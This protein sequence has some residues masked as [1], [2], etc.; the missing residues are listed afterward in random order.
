MKCEFSKCGSYRYTLWRAW[1]SAV[2][3]SD[4]F[5]ARF[6]AFIGLNPSTA[7]DLRNDPT[8]RRCIGFARDWGF[9]AFCML[10]LFA[11][12]TP[13]P[14]ALFREELPVGAFNNAW[15]RKIVPLASQVIAAW[16]IHGAHMGRAA[17]V[18]AM[19]PKLDCLGV[20]KDGHPR[21]PLYMP[22]NTRPVPFQLKP[23]R[24]LAL[25]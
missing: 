8:I 5:P 16:G 13:H 23:K 12:R 21:H 6:V 24:P 15:L 4:E 7:D 11:L 18:A 9:E 10:N 2:F 20:T 3:S 22:H 14:S 1:G 19:F 25:K 17:A